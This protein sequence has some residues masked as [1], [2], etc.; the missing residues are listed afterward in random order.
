[1]GTLI[2]LI[3]SVKVI[4]TSR[5]FNVLYISVDI[6]FAPMREDPTFIFSGMDLNIASMDEHEPFC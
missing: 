4:Y 2:P 1:M 5:Y 6:A 3:L